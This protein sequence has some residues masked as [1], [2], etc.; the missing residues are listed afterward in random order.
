ML[1]RRGQH[2]ADRHQIDGLVRLR[3]R[4]DALHFVVLKRADRDSSKPERGRLKA[5]ILRRMPASRST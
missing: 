5:D 1:S 4:Y 3:K 2:Q